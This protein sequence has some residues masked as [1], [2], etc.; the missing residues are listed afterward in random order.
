MAAAADAITG[1]NARLTSGPFA[2]ETFRYVRIAN[3]GYV[4]QLMAQPVHDVIPFLPFI[5]YCVENMRRAG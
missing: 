1:D 3:P 4:F 2:G 5:L